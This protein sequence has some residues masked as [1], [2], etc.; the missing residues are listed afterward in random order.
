MDRFLNALMN[1]WLP[2]SARGAVPSRRSS[3]GKRRHPRRTPAPTTRLGLEA[4]EDR[5]MPSC[6]CY[7]S[8]FAGPRLA[9]VDSNQSILL[10]GVFNAI[11][12]GSYVHLSVTDWNA[13]AAGN[14][15]LSGL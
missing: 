11:L 5:L 14:V 2:Q 9:S 6:D 15:R 3:A 4:L 8:L 10:E 1:R 13:I 7:A 12:P